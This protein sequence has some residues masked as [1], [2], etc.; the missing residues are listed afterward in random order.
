M[1]C[2]F[3][4]LDYKENLTLKQRQKIVRVLSTECEE[5][6]TDATGIAYYVGNRLT[7]QKAPKPAHKRSI[8]NENLNL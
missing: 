5:R 3:G 6:G 4:I 1:C 7:T 8:Q 2:L